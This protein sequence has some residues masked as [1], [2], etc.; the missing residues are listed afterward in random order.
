MAKHRSTIYSVVRERHEGVGDPPHTWDSWYE[1]DAVCA[2]T[3]TLMRA[4]ELAAAYAQQF[5]DLGNA[6][7]YRFTVHP[8]TFYDE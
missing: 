4:E 6:D 7:Y 2:T 5:K 8:T 1:F 3:A